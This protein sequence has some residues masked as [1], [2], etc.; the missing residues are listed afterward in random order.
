MKTNATTVMMVPDDKEENRS[1]YQKR[2]TLSYAKL[3][4]WIQWRSANVRMHQ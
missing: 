3:A 1:K 2:L 4:A